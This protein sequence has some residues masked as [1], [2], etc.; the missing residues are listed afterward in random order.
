MFV[1][2]SLRVSHCAVFDYMRSADCLRVPV[3]M[4]TERTSGDDDLPVAVSVFIAVRERVEG[5]LPGKIPARTGRR[6]IQ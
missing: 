5:D 6:V 1:L 4:R 3:I 2:D